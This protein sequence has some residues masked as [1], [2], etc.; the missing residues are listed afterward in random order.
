M[1]VK[2][3]DK[4]QHVGNKSE[5]SANDVDDGCYQVCDISLRGIIEKRM[6]EMKT[7]RIL[8][9]NIQIHDHLLLPDCK[10]TI[11]FASLVSRC[12]TIVDSH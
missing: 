7:K 9:G 1:K 5:W 11:L 10:P 4:D 3:G 2:N 12:I 8:R 6:R